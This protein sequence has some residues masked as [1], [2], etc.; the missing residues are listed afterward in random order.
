MSTMPSA[1]SFDANDGALGL[2][3]V[4]SVARLTMN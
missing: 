1:P 3:D 4:K 2:A